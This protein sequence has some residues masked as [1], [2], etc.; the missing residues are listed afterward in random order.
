[1]VSSAVQPVTATS[2]SLSLSERQPGPAKHKKPH[3]VTA[4]D[5]DEQLGMPM[6]S[7]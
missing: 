3:E 2:L 7:I 6:L 5:F 4:D 1:M